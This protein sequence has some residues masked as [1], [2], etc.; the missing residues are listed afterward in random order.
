MLDLWILEGEILELILDI[1]RLA[2]PIL[3]LRYFDAF[4]L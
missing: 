3:N 4:N 1:L 2:W